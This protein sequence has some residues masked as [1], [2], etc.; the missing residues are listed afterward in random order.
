MRLAIRSAADVCDF[1]DRIEDGSVGELVVRSA[2]PPSDVRGVVFVEGG[3]V[4]WAAARG[5][6]PRLTELLTLR[7]AAMS[8]ETMEDLF[9]R[10]RDEGVPLGEFLVAR[11]IIQSNDLRS[12]L[13]EHT[14]ESLAKLCKP[15]SEGSFTLRSGKGYSPRFTFRTAEILARA[16][17][18]S[19]SPSELDASVEMEARLPTAFVSGEWGAAYLRGGGATPSPIAVHGE[20]PDKTSDVLRVGKWAASALDLAS[21]FDGEDTFVTAMDEGGGVSSVFV[22]WPHGAGPHRAFIAGRMSPRGPARLLNQR[23]QARRTNG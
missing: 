13:L 14:V 19:L 12:V 17:R 4:C 2:A 10:C 15:D 9:R 22:A 5:L 6:A 1:V 8:G 3:R 20:L 23:A 7:A 16:S 11:G 18:R 21:T